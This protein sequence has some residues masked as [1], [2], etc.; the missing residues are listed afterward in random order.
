[1]SNRPAR[2]M[3][4]S[5]RSGLFVAA[6]TKTPCSPGL[7]DS[8]ATASISTMNCETTRSSTPPASPLRPLHGTRESSSS[9]NST[10][11][12]LALASAN[13]FLRLRSDSPTYMSSSSGPLTLMKASAHSVATARATSVLPVPGGPYSRIPRP[14]VPRRKASGCESGNC[15]ACRIS[16]RTLWKAD[17]GVMRGELQM[18]WRAPVESADVRPQGG[19]NVARPGVLACRR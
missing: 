6:M 10:H 12:C 14:R 4:G 2:S 16:S 18:G 1:M 17:R 3:A 8:A 5:S 9:K 19:G 13:T 7:S 15:S 11:G